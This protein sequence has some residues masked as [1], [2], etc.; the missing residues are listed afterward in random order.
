MEQNSHR[1][2]GHYIHLRLGSGNILNIIR[3]MFI[4]AFK[5]KSAKE[6][7]N[8]WNPLFGYYLLFYLYKPL[9][10]KI[11]RPIRVIIT[12]TISGFFL[13]DLLFWWPF[14]W[15]IT[16]KTRFPLGTVW[17]I[18]MAIFMLIFEKI[19]FNTEKHSTG[20][21]VLSNL[22]YLSI[23][24]ALTLLVAISFNLLN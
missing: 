5:A 11:P 23:T 2:L 6:F 17:F 19:G 4:K 21:R 8:Y 14:C 1:T 9:T 12:F 20:I 24:L 15:L 13:H 3:S 10:N 22:S 16:Y 7:W 18:F